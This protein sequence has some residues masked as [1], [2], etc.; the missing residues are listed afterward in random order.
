MEKL[1]AYLLKYKYIENFF[2]PRT[3]QMAFDRS[4]Q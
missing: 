2:K 4:P 1:Q 3:T